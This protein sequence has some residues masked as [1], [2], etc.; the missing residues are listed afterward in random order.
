MRRVKNVT[1]ETQTIEL[2]TALPVGEFAAGD[3]EPAR[4]LRIR[5]WDQNGRIVDAD[6]DVVVQLDAAASGPE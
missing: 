2:A 4:H 3:V 1:D 6:G 5:R